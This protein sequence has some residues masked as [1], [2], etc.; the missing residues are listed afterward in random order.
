MEG[1]GKVQCHFWIERLERLRSSVVCI[2]IRDAE[3]YQG[4]GLDVASWAE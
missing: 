2:Y 3:I 1:R 4:F